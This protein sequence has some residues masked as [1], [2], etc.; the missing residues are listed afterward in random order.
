MNITL[1]NEITFAAA[2]PERFVFISG[3]GCIQILEVA[4][5]L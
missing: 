4:A 2:K 1:N 5:L 3:G